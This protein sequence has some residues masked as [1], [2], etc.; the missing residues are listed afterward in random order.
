MAFIKF[1]SLVALMGLLLVFSPVRSWIKSYQ[2]TAPVEVAEKEQFI[3]EFLKTTQDVHDNFPIAS[4]EK[5]L[6]VIEELGMKQQEIAIRKRAAEWFFK[7]QEYQ[8][9][10]L[11]GQKYLDLA[12]K[13]SLADEKQKALLFLAKLFYVRGESFPEEKDQCFSQA[14]AYCLKGLEREKEIGFIDPK[15]EGHFC[16]ILGKIAFNA[17]LKEALGFLERAERHLFQDPDYPDLVCSLAKLYLLSGDSSKASK[18]LSQIKENEIKDTNLRSELIYLEAEIFT[19]EGDL[20][21]AFEKI[22]TIYPDRK[23]V[24]K[25]QEKKITALFNALHNAENEVF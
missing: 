12:E 1:F 7:N 2:E 17:N 23:N 19:A 4:L 15:A 22:K 10:T 20:A 25:S 9:A 5:A 11:H 13:Y 6:K 8:L 14:K 18:I 16:L 21:K 3:E 24:S